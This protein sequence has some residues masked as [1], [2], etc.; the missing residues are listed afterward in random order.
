MLKIFLTLSEKLKNPKIGLLL[1]GFAFVALPAL[2]GEIGEGAR[3]RMQEVAAEPSDVTSEALKGMIEWAQ[4]LGFLTFL[5][6]GALLVLAARLVDFDP[7][8]KVKAD[9]WNG[10]GFAVFGIAF[11]L[12][13]VYQLVAYT[14][15]LVPRAAS[16]HGHEIDVLFLVTL[17]ITGLVFVITQFALFY[18]VSRYR[19][20]PD[21]LKARWYP[22]NHKLEL[23]WTVIPAIALCP[24]VL[25]GLLVWEDVHHPDLEGKQPL[26]I[27]VVG[28]Q[29]Q[30]RF[31]YPGADGKLGAT[32]FKLISGENPV[33]VDSSDVASH[34]D[35]SLSVKEIHIPIGRPVKFN[36]R[37]K[38]VLHGVYAPHFR[39]NIYAVPG[40][41]THF[42]FKPTITTEQMR[43]ELNNP[44][45]NYE[46]LCSQLC[47]NAHYNMRAVIIVDDEAQ[48]QKWLKTQT[49]GKAEAPHLTLGENVP[50]EPKA[51]KV[52]EI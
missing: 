32:K 41:P 12:F 16:E 51:K 48:Y 26:H 9:K 29:F 25:K 24:L 36:I 11:F 40:M 23:I 38:D 30:W 21:K 15:R 8:K 43:K 14:D 19:G 17:G 7:F 50:A 27:E 28:E 46:L 4:K 42:N 22:D 13:I 10:F 31:R 45:F 5:I 44:K 33:G 3:E 18:F 49:G 34:D 6:I 47:G 37:S 20:N 1:L 39:V 2:A 52:G 35:F